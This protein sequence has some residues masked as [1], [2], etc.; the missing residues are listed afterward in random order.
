[1]SPDSTSCVTHHPQPA[2]RKQVVFTSPLATEQLGQAKNPPERN[3]CPLE[4]ALALRMRH[5]EMLHPLLR[6]SFTDL[7]DDCLHD[8]ATY[9]YHLVKIREMH[10]NHC[11]TVPNSVQTLGV[12]LQPLDDVKMREDFKALH[13]NYLVQIEKICHPLASLA[14][15]Y[16]YTIDK[17]NSD[18]HLLSSTPLRM[19]YT[20]SAVTVE[21]FE[22]S[23]TIQPTLKTRSHHPQYP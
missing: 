12:T 17:M 22:R 11:S 21:G 18:L 1:M 8:Y 10:L 20:R 9:Y 15:K 16:V 14:I 2:S 6:A 5:I 3:S 7:T 4:T 23:M 19:L 13:I